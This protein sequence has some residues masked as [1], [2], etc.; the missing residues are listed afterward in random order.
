MHFLVL[1]NLGFTWRY[2]P[3]LYHVFGSYGYDFL[4]E[5]GWSLVQLPCSRSW[6]HEWDTVLIMRSM[7][8]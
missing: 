3:S 8:L 7:A 1:G 5:H 6:T 2:Q 4:V